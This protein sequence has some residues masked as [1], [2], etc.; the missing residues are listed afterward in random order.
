MARKMVRLY[1][2]LASEIV[3]G[4]MN[5]AMM[6]GESARAKLWWDVLVRIRRMQQDRR[7]LVH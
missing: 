5:D 3:L 2:E 7:I 1:P 4:L 6:I